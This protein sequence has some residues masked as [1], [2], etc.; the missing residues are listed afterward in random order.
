MRAVGYAGPDDVGLAVATD[1]GVV[2]PVLRGVL[3]TDPRGLAVARKA[4]VER[5]KAGRLDPEDLVDPPPSTLSNLGPFGVDQFTGV[6]ALGQ[7]SLVTVGRAAPR[8]V[9]DDAHTLR[10]RTSF[11]ATVNADH[12]VI[13]GAGVARLLSAFADV[14]QTMAPN[15]EGVRD[16]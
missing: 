9:A 4:A 5:A 11:F 3:A 10:I 15:F 13:D 8:V 6:I 1:F 7:T 14:A 16:E 2:I 12:R